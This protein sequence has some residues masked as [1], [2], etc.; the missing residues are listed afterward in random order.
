M[1]IILLLIITIFLVGC[2]G[3]ENNPTPKTELEKLPPAT[4]KGK[5]TFGC[6]VN[7]KA[8][9]TKTSIDAVAFYQEGTF[10]IGADISSP[11]Q[12]IGLSIV[13]LGTYTFQEGNFDLTNIPNAAA[14]FTSQNSIICFYEME[15]TLNGQLTLTRVDRSNLIV[16]GLFEFTTVVSECDTIKVTDGRFDLTYAN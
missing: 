2:E 14:E 1:R 3:C 11:G 5:N 7:G 12:S 10:S 9:V 15:N 16:S 6:L 4:Q 13:E 8:W